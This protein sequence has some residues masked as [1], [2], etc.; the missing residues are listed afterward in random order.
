LEARVDADSVVNL[1]WE[2]SARTIGLSAEVHRGT[3][4]DF[5]PENDTLL[6]ATS[7]FECCDVDAPQGD[8]HYAVV[9]LSQDDRSG[10]I[11][12]SVTVPPPQPPAPPTGLV[13]TAAPGRV[14]LRWQDSG[15]LRAR[16]HVYRAEAGTDDFKRLTG[17][18]TPELESSDTSASEGVQYAY[19][20]KATSRSGL[21]SQPADPV[22]SGALPVP[23][24]PV[25]IAAFTQDADAVLYDDGEPAPG[26][27]THLVGTFDGRPV[28]EKGGD[29]IRTTWPGTL[30]VGQYSGAPGPPYQ[31]TGWISGLRIYNRALDAEDAASAFRE[32][33][34]PQRP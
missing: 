4:P 23:Q 15:D 6:T 34:A 19:T 7:L 33:T 24:E 31:V 2:R 27:W 14:E 16:Y 5:T 1:T 3:R 28:A 8:P 11:R 22:E 30:R 13:A 26:R 29:A 9:L 12:T 18:P 10:P 32:N 17:E 20:I 25:M 21:E